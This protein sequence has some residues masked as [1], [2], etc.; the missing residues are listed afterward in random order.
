MSDLHHWLFFCRSALARKWHAIIVRIMAIVTQNRDVASSS[1]CHG[2][3]IRE[4]MP[5]CVL[6][7]PHPGNRQPPSPEA[8]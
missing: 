5:C 3:K 7:C 2:H 8:S 4:A 1:Y 6:G